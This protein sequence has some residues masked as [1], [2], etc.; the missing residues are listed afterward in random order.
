MID[1]VCPRDRL[2]LTRGG[3][4]LVCADRHDYPLVEGV[5]VLLVD[6]EQRT[7]DLARASLDAARRH[8]SGQP[9]D[10]RWF[11]S[12]LGISEEEKA[13]ILSRPATTRAEID[14]VVQF[15]I[16]ATN[17]NLYKGLIGNMKE[18]PVPA[19]R[20][21]RGAGKR[22]LD[23]GCNWGRWSL[24][25]AR[26]GYQVV[27]IDPSLGAI[28]AARRV[29][30]ELG[31]AADFVVGD[32]RCLPFPDDY[33]D[34]VFSY[35]VLQHF[36]AHDAS[37]ALGE[38]RRVLRDGGVSLIQMANKFGLRSLYHQAC[39]RF[40]TPRDF[41]VRYWSVPE[42]RRAFASTIGNPRVS[43]DCFL[44]LGL[45]TSDASMMSLI[46]RSLIHTSEFLRRLSTR[47]P[48]L[49][50]VADSLYI[51]STRSGAA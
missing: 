39:R 43:A 37:R 20:M 3:S 38:V 5:P 10:D 34:A 29:S 8:S 44:G 4:G 36:A 46:G 51:E 42:L 40:R 6:D 32:A 31:L 27:G 47:V 7:I 22:L 17:G 18:Y 24:A 25:A 21:P 33:F 9:P 26:I 14:P 15:M 1:L 45:Q 19:L 13:G 28:L 12:T 2:P 50:Y 41:E 30:N 48:A 49:I 11:T 16:G 23:V 35:S